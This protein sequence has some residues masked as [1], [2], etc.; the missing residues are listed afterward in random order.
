M[1]T[2]VEDLITN[3][4]RHFDHP[5]DVLNEPGL[6]KD[7]KRRILESWQLDAQRLAES[8]A[9]NMSGGEET[10]LRDVSKVLVQLK[11][12]ED[13]PPVARQ[14]DRSPTRGVGSGMALGGLVGAGAGLLI[15]TLIGASLAV[16]A[17]AAVVGV[18]IG[19]VGATLRNAVRK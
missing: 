4:T 8:T 13:A 14:P 6:T 17:Q 19:G 12:M 1:N 15:N 9:E 2:H 10:D 5:A 11:G 18:I 3:P 16:V 7:E